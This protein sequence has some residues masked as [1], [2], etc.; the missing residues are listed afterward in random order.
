MGYSVS[1]VFANIYME[2]FGKVSKAL[3]TPYL[4]LGRKDM[5]ILL[6]AEVKKKK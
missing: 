1:Q 6:L 3:N 4:P 5:C 2:Y